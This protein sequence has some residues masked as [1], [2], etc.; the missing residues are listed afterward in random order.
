MKDIGYDLKC[1]AYEKWSET[2]QNNSNLKPSLSSLSYLL[3]STMD[4][5]SYLETQPTVKKTNIETYLISVNSK[6][7]D[8]DRKECHRILKT[9]SNLDFIPQING[10]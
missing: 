7:P 10:N 5:K 1:I 4:D 2:I 6:Y 9:L 8:L 3:N